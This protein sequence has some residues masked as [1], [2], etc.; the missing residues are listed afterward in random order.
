MLNRSKQS[1]RTG[2]TL[3]ELMITVAVIGILAMIAVPAYRDY[4]IRSKV[5]EGLVMASM[6]KVAVVESASSIGLDAVNTSNTGSSTPF[7]PT[8]YVETLDIEDGGLIKVT[9]Q[10]TGA[11]IDPE[12][13]LIPSQSGGAITWTCARTATTQPSHVPPN[14]RNEASGTASPSKPTYDVSTDPKL[15]D[16]TIAAL[17]QSFIDYTKML[18][19][20]GVAI[21][22]LHRDS[23]SL[24][25]NNQTAY[26]DGYYKFAGITD[27]NRTGYAPISDFKVFY[28][29][30]AN[31]KPTNEVSGVYLQIGGSRRI[32]FPD[33]TTISQK[34][35]SDYI[36]STTK[37]LKQPG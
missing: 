36:D 10:N 14:C 11:A 2:F 16:D 22:T 23:G 33:G 30:D 27:F 31:G 8:N 35:Y 19:D 34:H 21:P 5:S 37:Q 6:M 1:T 18:T 24:S 17:Y 7:N 3:I 29:R 4:S 13:W 20:S 9:T 15:I 25:W 32:L 28:K 26:W 12:L